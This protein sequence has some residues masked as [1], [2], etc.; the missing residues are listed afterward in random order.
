MSIRITV[1]D[2]ENGD[3]DNR[4]INNNFFIVTAGTAYVASQQ[5]RR[6]K[7]GTTT[8]VLTVKGARP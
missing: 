5:I 7:D 6:L 1:T 2:T 3:S 8:T 4:E